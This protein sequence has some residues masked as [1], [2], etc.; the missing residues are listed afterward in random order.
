MDI[1]TETGG[2]KPLVCFDERCYPLLTDLNS[3]THCVH[4]KIPRHD[5]NYDLIITDYS[6]AMKVQVD[7]IEIKQPKTTSTADALAR[8]SIF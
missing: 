5:E 3:L 4:I 1:I 2:V 7:H 6:K 8:K